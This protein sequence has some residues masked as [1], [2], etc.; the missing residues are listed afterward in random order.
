M[1]EGF[2][3]INYLR[4]LSRLVRLQPQLVHAASG[5]PLP[6]DRQLWAIALRYRATAS[7]LICRIELKSDMSDWMSPAFA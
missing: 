4:Q 3:L 7:M 5:D 2:T 6:M 1:C